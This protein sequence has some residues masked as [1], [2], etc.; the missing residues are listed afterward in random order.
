MSYTELGKVLSRI[1]K[2]AV[3]VGESKEKMVKEFKSLNDEVLNSKIHEAITF[4][5]AVKMAHD[6]A[7]NGEI[8]ILSP[9]CASF[10][11]FRNFEKRGEKFVEIVNTLK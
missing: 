1:A 6:L 7:K 9:A 8:V 4:E 10:D 5:E 11:F 2:N 3:I